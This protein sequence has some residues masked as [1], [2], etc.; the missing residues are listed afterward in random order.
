[1][2]GKNLVSLTPDG[3]LGRLRLFTMM[4]VMIAW[5]FAA[6]AGNQ[7]K[8]KARGDAGAWSLKFKMLHIGKGG[9]SPQK[10]H[11]RK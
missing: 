7:E 4:M 1:M 8:P 9:I 11:A 6:T 5:A 3:D 2:L 10:E